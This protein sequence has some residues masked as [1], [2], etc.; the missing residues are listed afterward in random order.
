[1]ITVTESDIIIRNFKPIHHNCIFHLNTIEKSNIEEIDFDKYVK[2]CI[3]EF[4]LPLDPKL[5]FGEYYPSLDR[6]ILID[7][8]KIQV[9]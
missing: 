5:L 1:M 3:I 4:H 8:R 9:N 7:I 2:N 6:V